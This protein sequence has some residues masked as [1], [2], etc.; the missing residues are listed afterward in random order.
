MDEKMVTNHHFDE[1]LNEMK[2]RLKVENGIVKNNN[3]IWF[4]LGEGA[5]SDEQIIFKHGRFHLRDTKYAAYPV[6]RVTWYGAS[7]YARHYG[8]R[9]LTE[10]EWEYV[11]SKHMI[12]GKQPS[13]KKADNPQIN[14]DKTSISS[15]M[16]THM[17]DMGASSDKNKSQ[18]KTPAPKE[19]GENFKEWVIQNDT[20]KKNL[21]GSGSKENISYP[22]LVVATSQYP[23]QQF[24]NFRYPWEAFADVGFRCAISIGNEH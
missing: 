2:D 5:A 9:L 15:Q 18:S 4:Y 3:E 10:S 23:G 8:K 6:A 21:Y 13:G 12:P 19:L 7:A 1:F 20:G 14:N 24:K 17:M 22:S 11:V 16:R